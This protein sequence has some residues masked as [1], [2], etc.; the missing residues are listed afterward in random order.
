[1]EKK[2]DGF[3]RDLQESLKH[4]LR[5]Y[6]EALAFSILMAFL[7]RYFVVAS[8]RVNAES[9]E[10]TLS[11]GDYILGL[12][13]PMGVRLPFVER[14]LGSPR[15]RFRDIVV[16]R[17]DADGS[18]DLCIKRVLGLP[19][20]LISVEGG[21]LKRNGQVISR[22]GFSAELKSSQIVEP[23]K[24]FLSSD[25]FGFSGDRF[26]WG[27]VSQDRL[28]ARA[29][30]VWYSFDSLGKRTNWDRIGKRIH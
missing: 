9:M 2:S 22:L 12:K 17:C 27:L 7:L 26:E 14:R 1:M 18:G 13:L 4:I 8:Y 25:R 20:D 21:E 16:A 28:E 6:A 30:L 15:P 29:V 24:V 19:G 11:R 23:G 10:P 5:D 3:G